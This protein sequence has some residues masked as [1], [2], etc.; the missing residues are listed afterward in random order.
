MIITA[1]WMMPVSGAP[2]RYGA[3]VVRD[4][5]IFDVGGRLE[6][7]ERYPDEEVS[8]HRGCAVVPG[9]VNAHTHLALSALEGLLPPEPFPDWL[10]RIT[11]VIRALDQ[12]DC[13]ASAA[14]GALACLKAGITVVGDIAYGPESLSAAGDMGLGGVYFWEVL[15]VEVNELPHVLSAHEFPDDP[16]ECRTSRLLCGISPHAPYTSGPEL[17]RA[18]ARFARAARVPLMI[19]LAESADEV[20]LLANGEGRL[21]PT[22]RRLAKGFAPP[23]TGAIRY[24]DSLGLLEDA[25]AVHCVQLLPGEAALLARHARGVVLCPRSNAHL[26]NGEPP[27][28]DL[29]THGV[30]MAIG[31]D[32]LASNSSIDLLSEARALRRIDR[33]LGAGMLLEMLTIGGARVLGVD[34]R[35]GTL[36]R[37]K[38]ADLAVFCIGETRHPMERL[39]EVG[40]VQTL[41]ATMAAGRWRIAD[42]SPV[43]PTGA[44]DRAFERVTAKAAWAL[45]RAG[46]RADEASSG[47]G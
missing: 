26:K 14:A 44:M 47:K 45:E 22:A 42:G 12:D 25:I 1:D 37:G 17:L 18:S 46:V 24:A 20:R 2:M 27:V 3:V 43:A 6:M 34:D 5:T 9:L 36:E 38:Q 7:Q 8:E 16:A 29:R 19:H 28:A 23:R 21:A 10:D 33:G 32:S 11:P 15:G 40:S 31:T 30:R 13:A 4:R 39:I 41:K 35:F